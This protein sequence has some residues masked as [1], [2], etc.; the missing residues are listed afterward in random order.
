MIPENEPIFNT[1]LS[2]NSKAHLL[3]TSRWTK[4]LAI[5]GFIFMGLMFLGLISMLFSRSNTYNLAPAMAQ[6]GIIGALI[7]FVVLI[8]LYI[9]PVIMLYRFSINIKTGLISGNANMVET[10]LRCQKNMFK[11]IGVLSIFSLVIYVI[12]SVVAVAVSFNSL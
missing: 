3:E 9:Y 12:M 8:G 2:E 1:V 4:F 6:M 10:A 7:F 11:Y 5:M